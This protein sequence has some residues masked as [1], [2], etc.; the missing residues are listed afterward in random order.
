MSDTL[1]IFNR[2]PVDVG[3]VIIESC[4]PHDI[5][6]LRMTSKRLRNIID[7][8]SH[9]WTTARANLARGQCSSVPAPP[10]VTARGNYNEASYAFWLFGGGRCDSTIC[11]NAAKGLPVSFTL[12]LRACSKKCDDWIF[13]SGLI[14]CDF[15]HRYDA[16]TWGLWLPRI[17][18]EDN[19][20]KFFLYRRSAIRDAEDEVNQAI[21]VTNGA[22]FC[23]GKFPLRTIDALTLEHRKRAESRVMLE[24]NAKQLVAW[25]IGYLAEKATVEDL[26]W[27]CLKTFCATE[28]ISFNQ[29]RH[30]PMTMALLEAFNRDLERIT[31]TVWQQHRL[32]LRREYETLFPD[33]VPTSS[34]KKHNVE[35]PECGRPVKAAGLRD[36]V[37]ARHSS[38]EDR[39]DGAPEH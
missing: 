12:R 24:K 38:R 1:T 30:C 9:V 13:D 34:L 3:L 18:F 14:Y 28:R 23:M 22:I 6:Q 2:F 4:S 32:V 31:L 39:E 8:H 19:G 36:H 25:K 16:T 27:A 35:C 21:A 15:K 5:V 10:E 7:R 29:L 26:N 37:Q 17:P 20:S 33:R 11:E